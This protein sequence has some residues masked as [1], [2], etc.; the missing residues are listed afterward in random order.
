MNESVFRDIL[1]EALRREFAE[2][3]NAPKHRFSRKHRR[4]MKKILADFQRNGAAPQTEYRLTMPF[5]GIKQRVIYALVIIILMTLLTGWFIP[6]RGITEVQIDWL[7]SKY[8][9]PA[10]KMYAAQPL[11]DLGNSLYSAVG[12]YRQ[13]DEYT[14]FLADLERLEIY[15][16][17]EFNTLRNKITP[18][19]KRPDSFKNECLI[20]EISAFR[21][22]SPLD[23]ARE[24]VSYLEN[25]MEYYFERSRDPARAVEGDAEFAELIKKNYL[26]LNSG[27]LELLEKLFAEEPEESESERKVLLNFDKDD[28]K[29]LLKTNKL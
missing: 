13:T 14:G 25:K 9:F 8:D 4:A 16:E 17:E 26:E 23:G 27:Y 15:S 10:M 29:Y 12:L 19:D 5:Y 7:R 28:K 18:M 21:S 6:I 2:F 11:N 20:E 1:G 24:H 3:D 22:K